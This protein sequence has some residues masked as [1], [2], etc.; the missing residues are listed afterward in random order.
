[1]RSLA[2][3]FRVTFGPQMC[4]V[5]STYSQ[6]ILKLRTY[7]GY[8]RSVTV[9]SRSDHGEFKASSRLGKIFCA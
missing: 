8:M 5:T 4:S 6:R 7:E 2:R 9:G 3:G 1:M